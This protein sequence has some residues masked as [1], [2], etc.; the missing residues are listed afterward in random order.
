VLSVNAAVGI[1]EGDDSDEQVIDEMPAIEIQEVV[2][3]IPTVSPNK[4]SI[5]Q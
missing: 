2:K 3:L 5:E 1:S 4:K